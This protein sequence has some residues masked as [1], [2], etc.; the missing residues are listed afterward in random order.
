MPAAKRQRAPA[1]NDDEKRLASFIDKFAPEH[2]QVIRDTRNALRQRF[3][4]ANELVYDNY[5]FFVIGYSPTERAS[6]TIVSLTAASNGVGLCFIHGASL[7]D[8]ERVLLGNG[9]QTRFVRL[10]SAKV[11]SRPDIEALIMAAIRRASTPIVP[12]IRGR[13]IIKSVSAKQ[14][15]RRHS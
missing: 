4:G 3:R 1:P 8:P 13:L 6:D 12:T 2:Q 7:P 14:R 9:K 11:L 10:D 15:P 5:N